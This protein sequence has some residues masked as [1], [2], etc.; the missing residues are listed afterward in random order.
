MKAAYLAALLGASTGY[1]HSIGQ[2]VQTSSGQVKGHAASVK[3]SVSTYLGIPY[4]EPPVGSLRFMPPKKYNGKSTI[5]GGSI[6]FACPANT[7][8]AARGNVLNNYNVN[9][10]NLTAQ[11]IASM[12]QIAQI[13]GT[14]SED[15]LTLN[16]WVPS[17]GESR[18]AV[19]IWVH[20]GSYTS[21]STQIPFYDGQHLAAEQDLIIVTINYRLDILGFHGNPESKNYNPGFLDQR[22]AV[23]WVKENIAA[24]GGDTSRITLT[25]QSAG[26]AA[27]DHYAYSWASD[28]I[29]SGLIMESGA[30]G[31]GEAL[32]PNNAAEWYNVS[33]T[34]GCGARGSQESSK[35]LSCLQSKPIGE[36]MAA[37]GS[38]TFNP[39]ADNI[40]GFPD[41]PALSK[42][43]KFAKLPV[44]TGNNDFE[45]GIYILL[46]ALYN[47]TNDHDHWVAL[48][49]NVFACPAGARANVSASHSL[50]IWRYR[51]F[52]NFPNTRLMTNPD[53]GAYHCSE[54]PFVFDTLPTGPG[55]AANTEAEISI[56]KYVRGAWAAFVKNPTSGLKTYE[57]GWPQYSPSEPS[58][59]RLAYNNATGTNVALPQVYDS[60]CHTTY[61]ISSTSNSK[62]EGPSKNSTLDVVANAQFD[63]SRI[64]NHH[65][66]LLLSRIRTY[67]NAFTSGDFNGIKD[68]ESDDYNMTDIPI[69]VVR[70]PKLSWFEQNKGFTNLLTDLEVQA[71]SLYGSSAPGQFAI[72]EHVVW[73]RLKI[74][75]PEPAKPNLPPGI[76]KGDKAG[77]INIAVLWWNEE[78]KISHELEYGRLTWEGFDITAFDK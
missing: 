44:L 26:A 66:K 34:L 73:F 29:V 65:D 72:M 8:F 4:A 30:A 6:G 43:G 36:L 41:Y 78:G 57:G 53:S 22:M 77:M 24:F 10:A 47:R 31:F 63:D 71:I 39:S 76:K 32:P 62:P 40:T 15:C 58:L 61:P 1:G 68:L 16:V 21:G 46:N 56:G 60:T 3:S 52:G 5:D 14:F 64:K 42:A 19:M 38:N 18:K 50:P 33:A 12:S 35:I 20:G 11:G 49:D 69:S 45:A 48:T 27:V 23:E 70:S 17:G 13:G 28:P 55:I 59:I 25:G 51:W 74:D 2:T 9:L 37:I 54:I 75:P 67:F 7:Y